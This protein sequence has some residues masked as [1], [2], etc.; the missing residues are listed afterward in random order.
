VSLTFSIKEG[1]RSLIDTVVYQ[2]FENLSPGVME[3]LTL[4]KQTQV[5]QPYIKNKV[6]EESHR[7]IEVF[8]N[9]DM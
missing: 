8:A 7:I 1:R 6:E 2:G 4:N 5:G 3:E 9:N